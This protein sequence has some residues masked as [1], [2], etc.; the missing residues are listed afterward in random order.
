MGTDVVHLTDV[1][2]STTEDTAKTKDV[3]HDP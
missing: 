2:L 3:V 1:V